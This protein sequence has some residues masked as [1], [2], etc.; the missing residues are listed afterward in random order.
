MLR[1][2]FFSCLFLFSCE[3]VKQKKVPVWNNQ[4]SIEMNKFLSKEEDL[5]IRLFLKNR[6]DLKIEE[7]GTGLRFALLKQ[8][9]GD[10]IQTNQDANVEY[11]VKLLD[12]TVCYQTENDKLDVFRVDKSEMES[13]IHEGIKKMRKGD[14]AL[15][16][17]P[18]HLAHGLIGNLG[19]IPPL[20]PLMIEIEL[21][22]ITL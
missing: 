9:K 11:S 20:S 14:K 8:G 19:K 3:E 4:K 17:F 13:G 5:A 1:I 22:D 2:V 21:I 6:T 10:V 16:I 18:S 7:S 15:F 12:G